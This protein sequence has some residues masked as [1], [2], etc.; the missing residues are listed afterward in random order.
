MRNGNAFEQAHAT[1]L[2]DAEKAALKALKEIAAGKSASDA[3]TV[4][5]EAARLILS[6]RSGD[7]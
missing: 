2:K 7:A 3:D 6:I 4:R 1:E 5:I